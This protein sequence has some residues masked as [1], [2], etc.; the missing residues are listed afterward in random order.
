MKG[1]L[2]QRCPAWL[3]CLFHFRGKK[4]SKKHIQRV[5]RLWLLEK[6]NE[7]ED[8]YD[9]FTGKHKKFRRKE[10]LE[11]MFYSLVKEENKDIAGAEGNL[12]IAPVS[13]Y[14]N[15]KKSRDD[16][17]RVNAK[18]VVESQHTESDKNQQEVESMH[19]VRW[20][21]T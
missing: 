11:G 6:V 4:L 12:E 10:R 1:Q 2:Q 5:K 7:D 3:N 8:A 16:D 18:N 13:S 21:V 17:D 19:E 20:K 14:E 15:G 9:S